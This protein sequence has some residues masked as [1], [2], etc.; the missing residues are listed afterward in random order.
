MT[1]HGQ[2]WASYQ[3]SE[4]STKGIDFA[5]IK[6]TQGTTYTNPKMTAQAAHARKAGCVVGFY[7]F[8]Q[9][10]NIKAQAAYFVAQAASVGGDPLFADWET[11]PEGKRATCDEKDAFLAEVKRLRGDTHRVGL[12][13]NRDF[14]LNHDTTGDAGDALWIAD[15]VGAGK[16]RITAK[17][18]FHQYTSTPVDTN[19]AAFKDKAAL[20]AWADVDTPST[21]PNQPSTPPK[22][23]PAMATN[24]DL[25]E[26]LVKNLLHVGS[27][28]EVDAKG[29]AVEHGAGYFLAHVEQDT[30][31]LNL[32]VDRIE[33]ALL[34]LAAAVKTLQS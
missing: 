6:A 2:D 5:I 29:K 17:W 13:C 4:P 19:V 11:T 21:P 7:H 18:L 14:W 25:L 34:E 10:G 26:A 16:P 8:L 31:A 30:V 3:P 12:Y 28:T 23:T 9:P 1:V 20:R 32:K 24:T 22:G 33:K 15:Y 27:L